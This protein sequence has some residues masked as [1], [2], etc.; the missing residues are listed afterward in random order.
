MDLG[1]DPILRFD[2]ANGAVYH[3]KRQ[4]QVCFWQRNKCFDRIRKIF[5]EDC[6]SEDIQYV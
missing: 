5:P 2:K 4:I 6:I 1:G 3:I